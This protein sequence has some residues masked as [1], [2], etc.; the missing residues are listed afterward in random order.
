[1]PGKACFSVADLFEE[2]GLRKYAGL[3]RD[4]LYSRQQ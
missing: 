1:M 4:R 2:T 3:A